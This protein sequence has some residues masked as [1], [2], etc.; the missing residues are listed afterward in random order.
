MIDDASEAKGGLYL[1][2]LN[3]YEE[4]RISFYVYEY[5]DT[6]LVQLEQTSAAEISIGNLA[7]VETAQR[8]LCGTDWESLISGFDRSKLKGMD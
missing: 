4:K 3:R 8:I 7:K 1:G 6:D 5:M 2:I